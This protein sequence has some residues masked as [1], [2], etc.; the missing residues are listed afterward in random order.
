MQTTT[1]KFS[2]VCI[3]KSEQNSAALC[4]RNTEVNINSIIFK[5]HFSSL[6]GQKDVSLWIKIHFPLLVPSLTTLILVQNTIS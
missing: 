1:L 4:I 3:K 2:H 5:L 6:K